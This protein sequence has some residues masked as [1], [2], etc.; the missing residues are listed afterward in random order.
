[1]AALCDTSAALENVCLGKAFRQG[2]VGS[3]VIAGGVWQRAR[4]RRTRNDEFMTSQR[5]S[6]R[7]ALRIASRTRSCAAQPHR[8]SLF[9]TAF[10]PIVELFVAGGASDSSPA[11]LYRWMGWEGLEGRVCAVSKMM[12]KAEG[13]D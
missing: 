7:V 3:R 11:A 9:S 12:E 4:V 6:S 10:R 2:V 5:T 8:T 1:L 13:G